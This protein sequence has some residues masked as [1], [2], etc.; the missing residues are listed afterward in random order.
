M[1]VRIREM[2]MTWTPEPMPVERGSSIL[3]VGYTIQ[4]NTMIVIIFTKVGYV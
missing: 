2:M 3:P 1:K 4:F